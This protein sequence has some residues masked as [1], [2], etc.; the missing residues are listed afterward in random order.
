MMQER[1]PAAAPLVAPLASPAG[2]VVSRLHPENETAA[3]P[4]IS[5]ATAAFLVRSFI[6]SSLSTSELTR[7]TARKGFRKPFEDGESLAFAPCSVKQLDRHDPVTS[8][9][10]VTVI[11]TGV[12]IPLA[13]PMPPES[14]SPC[15][16]AWPV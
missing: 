13:L 15:T 3:S 5:V 10:S 9:W 6:C 14:E 1:F 4:A 2:A 8:R 12:R 16:R 11:G 7:L